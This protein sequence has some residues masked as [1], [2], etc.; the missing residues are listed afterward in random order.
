MFEGVRIWPAPIRLE[1]VVVD[2]IGE[3]GSIVRPSEVNLVVV[4]LLV[5]VE[6]NIARPT[7]VELVAVVDLV[8][9]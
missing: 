4:V 7:A 1:G 2:L 9:V 8:G 6:G 5:G 3:E